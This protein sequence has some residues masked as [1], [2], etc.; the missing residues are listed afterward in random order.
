MAYSRYFLYKRQ[1]S[2]D[3]GQTWVDTDPLETTINGDPIATYDTLEECEASR[4]QKW[5]ATYSDSH[6]ESGACD[7]S[8]AI[9]ENEITMENLVS[10]E[11]G[12]CTRSL[13]MNAFYDYSGLTSVTM[14]NNI[15][16]IGKYAFGDCYNLI[17]ITIAAITPPT[18]GKNALQGINADCRIYV[19]D[20]SVSAYQTA[21]TD[22]ASKIYPLSDK[23]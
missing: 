4:I 3:G 19:P 9:T 10:L 18:L 23:P 13:D 12:D 21:W 8:S 6:T 14:S 7:S 15:T 20:A 11:I 16:S 17:S 1:F 5:L 2:Y 22:Y